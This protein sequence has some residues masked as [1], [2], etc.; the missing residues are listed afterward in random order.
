MITC[1]ACLLFVCIN[2]FMRDCWEKGRDTVSRLWMGADSSNSCLCFCVCLRECSLKWIWQPW[3]CM[4]LWS[5][6]IW[7]TAVSGW[8]DRDGQVNHG[9]PWLLCRFHWNIHDLVATYTPQ[10]CSNID[11]GKMAAIMPE[12][13]LI[14]MQC[15]MQVWNCVPLPAQ[16]DRMGRIRESGHVETKVFLSMMCHVIASIRDVKMHLFWSILK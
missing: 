15:L 6:F 9:R 7:L 10:A 1:I 11:L 16:L 3:L 12:L 4:P 13:V 8:G 2:V 14:W 5:S